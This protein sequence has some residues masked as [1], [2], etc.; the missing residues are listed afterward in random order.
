MPNT[1]DDCKDIASWKWHG[2]SANDL[3]VVV[4]SQKICEQAQA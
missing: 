3:K 1:M 4:T 2:R